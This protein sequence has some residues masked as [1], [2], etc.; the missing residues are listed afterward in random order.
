[1]IDRISELNIIRDIIINYDDNKKVR[2]LKYLK[3]NL[4]YYLLITLIE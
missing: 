4:E 3:V 1:M 2:Y